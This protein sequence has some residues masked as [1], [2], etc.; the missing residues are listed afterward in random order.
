MPFTPSLVLLLIGLVALLCPLEPSRA[1]P[2]FRRDDGVW[3]RVGLFTDPAVGEEPFNAALSA[4]LSLAV[5]PSSSRQ[6][7]PLRRCDLCGIPARCDRS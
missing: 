6:A 5:R 2:V 7:A 1:A 4:T 3:S